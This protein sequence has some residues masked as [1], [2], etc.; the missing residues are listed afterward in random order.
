MSSNG[1][2][3]IGPTIQF[4]LNEILELLTN[5]LIGDKLDCST[6][7]ILIGADTTIEWII[8]FISKIPNKLTNDLSVAHLVFSVV[9]F[10]LQNIFYRKFRNCQEL[11]FPSKIYPRAFAG[12]LGYTN[13][14]GF[15]H[16]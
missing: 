3:K 7:L 1:K 11:F 4:R 14:P 5:N 16:F 10:T 6:I 15:E 9:G 8:V 13:S 2:L 12:H